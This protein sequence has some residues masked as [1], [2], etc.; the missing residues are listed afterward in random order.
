MTLLYIGVNMR[1]LNLVLTGGP[2]RFCSTAV[3]MSKFQARKRLGVLNKDIEMHNM[4]YYSLSAPDISDAHYDGLVKEKEDIEEKYPELAK[5]K[6]VGYIA[7]SNYSRVFHSAPMLSLD[8]CFSSS[9]ID[10]FV[11]KITKL[12]SMTENRIE[13]IIEP[14]IDGLSL[15]VRYHNGDF[16]SAIT[17]GDGLVGEDVTSNALQIPTI[18]HRLKSSHSLNVGSYIEVRGE[19][20]MASQDF[21]ALNKERRANEETEWS[22]PRNAA[23]GAMRHLAPC[24]TADRKLS[25]FAYSIVPCSSDW[26]VLGESDVLNGLGPYQDTVL[27]HLRNMGFS[28]TTYEIARIDDANVQGDDYAATLSNRIYKTSKLLMDQRDSFPYETDG[29]VIKVRSIAQQHLLGLGSRAP[30]WALAYKY[31]SLERETTLLDIIIQ[32]GR[33]GALTPVAVLEPVYI[34]GVKVTRAL[35]HNEDE[36]NRL[37][38]QPGDQVVVKRSGDVIPQIVNKVDFDVSDE[39]ASDPFTPYQLPSTCPECGS[40]TTTATTDGASATAAETCVP[41]LTINLTSTTGSVRRCT[42]FHTCPAQIAHRIT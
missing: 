15:A 14:K 6:S 23:S 24:V 39:K 8:N 40:P 30:K 3:H 13:F 38:L 1:V 12:K 10:M 29:V 28:T 41:F 17:R 21:V 36:V 19:V 5:T 9:G 7:N 22:T 18:P 27:S 20:Y 25:F 42:A 16:V 26:K 31:A 11:S 4:K 37:Q 32:V 34:G 33:T 2:Y 35:L